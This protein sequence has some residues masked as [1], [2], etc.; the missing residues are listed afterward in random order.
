MNDQCASALSPPA[1]FIRMDAGEATPDFSGTGPE[2]VPPETPHHASF[3]LPDHPRPWPV[4]LRGQELER[5]KG[6][7]DEFMTVLSHELRNSLGAI[8]SAAWSLR[9]AVPGA[10]AAVKARQVIERQVAQMTRLVDDLLDVSR[11][12]RGQLSV[13]SER[14]DL[15]AIAADA[16]RTVSFIMQE[17]NHRLTMALPDGPVWL[18]AD[19]NRL[20]QAIVNLLL[21]AAKYTE[22]GG[23]IELDAACEPG[24]AIIRIR[25]NGIGIESNAL[26]LVFDLF[27][28]ANPSS[29]GAKAG[30][31][32]GLA[33]VRSLVEHHGGQVSAASA[34]LGRGSEFT[35][36]LP[37]IP[38]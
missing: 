26:P 11:L 4:W 19:A 25:D 27:S 3:G 24:E 32:I 30:L 12:R 8:R 9:K 6:P 38:D 18:R 13:H 7:R 34:G 23:S 10:S 31:G 21:N 35:I 2:A 1:G 33:L 20:E 22:P 14:V 15:C 16:I 5:D 29:R 17:R 28:Q 37:T 36:R